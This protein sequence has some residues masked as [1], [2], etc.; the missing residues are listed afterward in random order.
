MRLLKGS[1]MEISVTIFSRPFVPL[2][3][4]MAGQI[5]SPY[6]GTL[7]NLAS[8]ETTEKK[9]VIPCIT[10]ILKIT[11]YVFTSRDFSRALLYM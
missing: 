10:Q 5:K 7:T 2:Y 1:F 4:S 9:K 6:L 3:Q 11:T 8:E